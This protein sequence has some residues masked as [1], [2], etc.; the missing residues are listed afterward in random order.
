MGKFTLPEASE[1]FTTVKYSWSKDKQA[2]D[3]VKSWLMEKKLTTRVED[4]TPSQWFKD[5]NNKW[6]KDLADWKKAVNEY[7]ARISKREADRAAK[8]QRKKVA[9]KKAQIEALKKKAEAEAKAKA[10][11]EAKA[12]AL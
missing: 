3:Y 9:E 1:G 5:S 11:A 2:A 10:L 7:K 6:A 12:K 4:I 8:A